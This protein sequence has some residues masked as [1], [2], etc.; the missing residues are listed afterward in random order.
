M[1]AVRNIDMCTYV[2]IKIVKF[3]IVFYQL[4]FITSYDPSFIM[5]LEFYLE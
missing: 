1:I 3:N 4:T 5:I 2:C